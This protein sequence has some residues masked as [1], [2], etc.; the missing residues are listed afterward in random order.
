MKMQGFQVWN[1]GRLEL[2]QFNTNKKCL[3]APISITVAGTVWRMI[4]SIHFSQPNV[5]DAWLAWSETPQL[6]PSKWPWQLG[7][8]EI[9][10]WPIDTF[11][12]LGQISQNS[13]LQSGIHRLLI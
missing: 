6:L 12:Y 5:A 9:M 1:I 13:A 3:N 7:T 8:T 11:H 4:F 2:F 10:T